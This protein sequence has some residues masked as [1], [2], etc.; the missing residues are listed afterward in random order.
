M[1]IDTY[2]YCIKLFWYLLTIPNVDS[3]GNF[4]W[5]SSYKKHFYQFAAYFRFLKS[6]KQIRRLTLKNSA[7]IDIFW[8][9]LYQ[10]LRYLLTQTVLITMF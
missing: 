7:V 8:V 2:N 9:T 1:F 3:Q 4:P 10:L 5:V 6:L